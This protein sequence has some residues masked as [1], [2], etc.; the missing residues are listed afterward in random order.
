M[1]GLDA[2]T[3]KKKAQD[4]KISGNFEKI[5]E[6]LGFDLEDPAGYPKRK[7]WRLRQKIAKNQLRN[8]P[9][10][11]LVYLILLIYLQSFFPDCSLAL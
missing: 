10:K 6:M 4:L 8:I 9:Q 5:S 1:G 2:H 7:F 11:N 3:R